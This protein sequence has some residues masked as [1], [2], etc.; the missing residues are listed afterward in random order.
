MLQAGK[1]YFHVLERMYM[2]T[3]QFRTKTARMD[4]QKIMLVDVSGT[5]TEKFK[6][7]IIGLDFPLPC[8]TCSGI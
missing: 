5:K 2:Y 1:R 3:L 8:Y 6:Q 4:K 7:C